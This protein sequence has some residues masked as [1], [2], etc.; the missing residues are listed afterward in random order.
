MRKIKIKISAGK[1]VTCLCELSIV[2]IGIAI[3]LSVNNWL[4]TRNEKKDMA[5]YLNAVKLELETNLADLEM[6]KVSGS[7]RF[8]KDK[9]V[10]LSIRTAYFKLEMLKETVSAGDF[11][12]YMDGKI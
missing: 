1:I 6:F 12:S 9:E 5:L 7:M 8:V 11:N 10:L 3:M 2:V 4:T